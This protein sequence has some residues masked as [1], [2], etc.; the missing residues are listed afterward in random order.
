MNLMTFIL[1]LSMIWIVLSLILLPIGIEMPDK[2]ENG[3]ASSA[4][5]NP[6]MML[7]LGISFSISLILTIIY[8]YYVQ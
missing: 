2:I 6:R 8:F 3:H 5:K 4:P 1:V 7:K